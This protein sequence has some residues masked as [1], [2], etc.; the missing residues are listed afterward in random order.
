MKGDDT[1][2][3]Q[4][5]KEAAAWKCALHTEVAGL[6][7]ENAPA[8]SFGEGIDLS[9]DAEVRV[10]PGGTVVLESS[11]VKAWAG[12]ILLDRFY[13]DLKTHPLLVRARSRFDPGRMR[14]DDAMWETEIDGVLSLQGSGEIE[15][16]AEGPRVDV[17][18]SVP[19]IAL[20]PAFQ[21]MAV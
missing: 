2:E 11:T 7:F 14:V 5:S 10:E 13:L 9:L 17:S 16:A 1:L 4:V 12:E 19:P 8:E 18:L 6:A 20:A 3:V 21:L 15:K